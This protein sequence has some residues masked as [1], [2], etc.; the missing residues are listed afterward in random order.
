M[1]IDRFHANNHRIMNNEN[2]SILM[3]TS[4]DAN[5]WTMT[6]LEVYYNTLVKYL[7]FEDVGRIIVTG[8]YVRMDIENS[9]YPKLAYLLGKSL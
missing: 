3:A 1:V 7:G 6:T 8:C 4:A 5:D 9:D 2:K